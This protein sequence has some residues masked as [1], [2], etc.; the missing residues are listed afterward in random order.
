MLKRLNLEMSFIILLT[1]ISQG[2]HLLFLRIWGKFSDTFSN[3]SVLAVSGPIFIISILLWTFTTLP[4]KHMF[5]L[6]LLVG[7]Y[8]LMG[9]STA[10]VNLATGNITFKLAPRG[11]ATAF[12]TASNFSIAIAASL[13]PIIGGKFADF[14]TG[15]QLSWTLKWSAPGRDIALET[16]NFQSWDFF[17]AIAFVI[18]LYSLHRLA[19]VK[20]EGEVEEKIV[21]NQLMIEIRDEVKNFTTVGGVKQ[22]IDLPISLLRHT[23]TA[24]KKGKEAVKKLFNN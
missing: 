22:V 12:L 7:I 24:G 3:K 11:N 20:E 4:E 8:I 10:G 2:A 1:I 14:F 17:F 9:I 5:T 13:A 23:K 19:L 18:G 16:L 21:F 15:Y 6:P